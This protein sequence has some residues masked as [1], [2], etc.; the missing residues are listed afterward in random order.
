MQ[1][2]KFGT[3]VQGSTNSTHGKGTNHLE[4][5]QSE[6]ALHRISQPFWLKPGYIRTDHCLLAAS[7][8][9]KNNLTDGD[10]QSMADSNC[11]ETNNS[12]AYNGKGKVTRTG[13]ICRDEIALEA[14]SLLYKIITSV[15]HRSRQ[16]SKME[17]FQSLLYLFCSWS[18]Y[19]APVSQETMQLNWEESSHPNPKFMDNLPVTKMPQLERGLRLNAIDVQKMDLDNLKLLEGLITD[20]PELSL[21]VEHDV[22]VEGT[23]R[24]LK[25]R[26]S[27]LE[28]ASKF[29]ASFISN[30]MH[31][32]VK[33]ALSSDKNVLK[34]VFVLAYG[35]RALIDKPIQD[36]V[37]QNCVPWANTIAVKKR[38]GRPKKRIISEVITPVNRNIV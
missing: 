36:L 37:S 33:D 32:K 2:N 28:V 1:N 5:G 19:D 24:T 22:L 17:L 34:L 31:A 20:H 18:Q 11:T 12:A 10:N 35:L 14:S 6:M 15:L 3:F 29:F 4:G 9:E 26:I 16:T 23:V 21:L 13:P 38:R 7:K 30:E 8:F 25:Y 27:M